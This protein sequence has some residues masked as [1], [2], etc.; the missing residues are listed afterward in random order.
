MQPDFSQT[1]ISEKADTCIRDINLNPIHERKTIL[2][3]K[4]EQEKRERKENK[5][6]F[7]H[8][9]KF[10]VMNHSKHLPDLKKLHLENARL[11]YPNLPSYA[12]PSA[13]YS[14]KDANGLTACVIDW[15]RFSGGAAF[16]INSQGQYDAK[17]ERWRKSGTRPGLPDIVA[18]VCGRFVAIEIKFGR[19][20]QS[21]AQKVI[22]SEIQGAEGAYLIVRDLDSFVDWFALEL[23]DGRVP[24]AN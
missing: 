22:E 23:T 24:E 5:P 8:T 1:A 15:I 17:L 7:A 4:H 2:L 16:R 13:K 9:T 6:I 10:I 3:R 19:D 11:K 21:E 12:I 14:V 18:C 20:R